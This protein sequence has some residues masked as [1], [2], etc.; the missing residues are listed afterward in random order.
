[1]AENFDAIASGQPWP[2]AP[3]GGVQSATVLNGVGTLSGVPSTQPYTLARVGAAG[4]GAPDVEVSFEFSLPPG[5][6][7][8]FYVRQNGGFLAPRGLVSG[9]GYALFAETFRD[10]R[11]GLWREVGGVETEL[12]PVLGASIANTWFQAR[13]Q[14][15]QAPLPDGGLDA[16]G[17]RLRGRLW[18]RGTAEPSTW[19]AEL[20][21]RT[22]SLQAG[23]AS[24][25]FAVDAFSTAT[26]DAGVVLPVQ[27]D[28]L[29]VRRLR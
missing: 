12:R 21:D 19:E 3:L 22:A 29:V 4:C 14:V 10:R 23:S 7:V 27:V 9:A 11:F 16:L 2:W 13:F 25:G 18:P 5:S 17:T 26:P 20:V 28:N 6:G 15:E 1:V 8:G 24:T